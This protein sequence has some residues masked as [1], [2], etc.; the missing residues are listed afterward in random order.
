[1]ASFS[2]EEPLKEVACN[3][4]VA[5]LKQKTL[6]TTN[7][8]ATNNTTNQGYEREAATVVRI[9]KFSDL[10]KFVKKSNKLTLMKNHYRAEE[11]KYVI[12]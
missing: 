10:N 12:G 6:L 2:N 8:R 9:T 1:M 11:F 7:L 3:E 5:G 4:T